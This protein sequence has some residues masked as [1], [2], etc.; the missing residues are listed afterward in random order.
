MPAAVK[1]SMD[2]LK[3][4]VPEPSFMPKFPPKPIH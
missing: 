4:K 1:A 3:L 2:T